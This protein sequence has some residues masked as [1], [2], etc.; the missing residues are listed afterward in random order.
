MEIGSDYSKSDYK[1]FDDNKFN[2]SKYDYSKFN[3]SEF[4]YS[5]FDYSKFDY[6]K[7]GKPVRKWESGLKNAGNAADTRCRKFVP[8]AAALVSARNRHR[9]RR[10]TDT[11]NTAEFSDRI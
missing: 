5:K 10:K 1:I 6:S 2:Y 11:E 3:Y 8:I 9:I 7:F 4:N